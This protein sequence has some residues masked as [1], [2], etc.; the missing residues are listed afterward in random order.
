LGHSV[1]GG[2]GHAGSMACTISSTY[3]G[4]E[5]ILHGWRHKLENRAYIEELALKLF[6]MK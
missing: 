6:G 3:L 2:P 4:I 1:R 5:V